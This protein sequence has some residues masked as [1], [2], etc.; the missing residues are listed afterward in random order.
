MQA[1]KDRSIATRMRLGFALLIVMS[2]AV[3]AFGRVALKEVGQ[4]MHELTDKHMVVVSLLGQLKDNVNVTARVA[5]NIALLSEPAAKQREKARIDANR[6]STQELLKQL[7]AQ[8]AA[9]AGSELLQKV[10]RTREA[11]IKVIN[12]AIQ[13]G[14]AGQNEAARDALVGEVGRAQTE[15]FSAL[16][17]LIAMQRREMEA[18]GFAADRTIQR[19]GWAMLGLLM[20][21][22]FL[23]SGIAGWMARSVTRPLLAAMN[24][25]QRIAKGDLS[26]RIVA[27]S[28]DE[29]GQLMNSLHQM[30]EALRQLVG[31][32]RSSS[33]SVATGAGQ[34]ATGNGDLSQRTER[35]ASSLQQT[36]A[37]MEQ[38]SGTVTQSAETARHATDF[39]TA[40]NGAAERGAQVM[41]EVIHTMS[42]IN[43]A[44]R[45]IS[46]IVSVIDGIAFQT[47]ILALNA[48]VE[49]ARAGEEGRGFAVVASEVRSL[50]QR[51]ATA[52]REIKTL[53]SSNVEKVE[54]GSRLVGSAGNSM[55]DIRDQV[56]RVVQLINELGQA[57]Q[58]QSR[59]IVHINSAVAQLDEST[60][61]NAALVEQSAAAAES[62]SQQARILVEA[63]SAF[64]LESSLHSAG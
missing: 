38:L 9:E 45:R 56:A 51:S 2:M 14:M 41:G 50:A 49:A 24:V 61:Q 46:D 15:Y 48:A 40:A 32:V 13:L 18:A 10:T 55:Q 22:A 54:A 52:A 17:E 42:D 43:E 60:Q 29:V 39:A 23:G 58:A 36:A 35:Q 63:V 6:S 44:S 33:D 7:Q 20:L 28:R 8:L 19:A 11:Y 1:L 12:P 53:I 62:L 3:A 37:S 25:T 64:K 57:S 47:N 34:I 5:R 27:E 4:Q 16:D 59:D 21:S 30:Q 31:V 26:S